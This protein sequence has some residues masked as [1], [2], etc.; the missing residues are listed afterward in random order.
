MI[1]VVCKRLGESQIIEDMLCVNFE[2]LFEALAEWRGRKA[3]CEED[4]GPAGVHTPQQGGPVFGTAATSLVEPPKTV[5][6]NGRGG[7]VTWASRR[8][9]QIF[10]FSTTM[11]SKS[12]MDGMPEI[13]GDWI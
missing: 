1:Y 12:M 5:S 7:A 11:H 3:G 13:G 9:H 4:V 10:A 6:T 2:K 8:G